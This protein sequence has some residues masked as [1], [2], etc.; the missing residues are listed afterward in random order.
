MRKRHGG[1]DE[2]GTKCLCHLWEVPDSLDSPTCMGDQVGSLYTGQILPTSTSAA[3]E[4]DRRSHTDGL[5]LSQEVGVNIPET[6]CMLNDHTAAL[7]H[8][9]WPWI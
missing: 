8:E 4:G 5:F 9:S 6:G 1:K 7:K 3:L 2:E